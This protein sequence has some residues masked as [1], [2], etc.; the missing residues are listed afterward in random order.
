MNKK[1]ISLSIIVGA[2]LVGCTN[3]PNPTVQKHS[4]QFEE[5]SVPMTDQEKREVRASKNVNIDGKNYPIDFHTILR[6]G[7]KSGDGIFGLLYDSKGNPLRSPDG[8]LKI[9][10]S[11]DFTSLI[12]VEDKIF[13]INQFESR[14]AAMYITEVEQDKKGNLTAINTKNI[15]FSKFNGLWVPCAGSITPWNSHLGSEEYEPNAKAVKSNG[16]INNYYDAM[17]DYF[18]GNLKALNPYDYGWITEINVL[19][20]KADLK[21]EKHYAMGR[22][23]HELA[24]V[25]PDQKTVFLS[26]DGT[27]V[28]LFM[29]VAD[30][31]ADLS[32]GILYAAK[33]MQR[34]DKNG[35]KAYLAWV[36][37]GHATDAQIKK[38]L[39]KKVKFDD[40]FKSSKN[41][42]ENYVTI[43]TTMGNENLQIKQDMDKIA[44][45]LESRRFAAMNGATTEFRKME[46]ITHNPNKNVLYVAMSSIGKGMEDNKKKGKANNKY[47]KNGNNDIKLPYNPCGTVYELSFNTKSTYDLNGKKINSQYVP[48]LMAG[49]VSGFADTSVRGNKCSVTSLA[50]PDNISF[51][52]NS[53]TLLIGEDTGSGHQN[54]YLWSYNTDSKNLTRIETTPYG[55]E[56]TSLYFINNVKGFGYIMSVVQHPYGEG[57]ALTKEKDMPGVAN[58]HDQMRGYTG[59]MGPLPVINK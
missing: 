2:L 29:F 28:A 36:N 50:N 14:P 48:N 18:G 17:G 5:V 45:R 22:F 49:M 31:K 42:N 44:S 11:N 56:T 16:S 8:S 34:D 54:D 20:A 52:P 1:V 10:N 32:S 12:P 39:D 3:Q 35:G 59:Y 4:I 38:A 9:S 26:D 25:M 15:D 53:S 37:L 21:V 30:K 23:A 24:Y 40:I 51:I 33:W 19:N 6:S 27:N 41:P 43:N 7:E 55:S 47:D 46:G 58:T 13:M 57:D